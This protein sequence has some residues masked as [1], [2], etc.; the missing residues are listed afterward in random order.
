MQSFKDKVV[1]I[2]GASSG[3][4]EA[5]AMAFANEGAKL[6]LTARREEELQRVK[7][8]T[9]LPET[10][11]LVLP[12]DVTQFEKAK[13]AA[14]KVIAHFGRIDIMVHNAGVSQRSYINDTDL[15]V[16]QMLMN[17]NFYS[18]V[19]ITKAILPYMIQQKSG[20]FIVISSVAGKIGTIMRSGYNASK[21]ALQG[22]YDSLRAEGYK[23]NIKVT[24]ICPGYIRTNISLNALNENGSK[25]GKMDANQ[26][27]GIAP[28]ECAA[29]I[30]EAVKNDK[31][32]IYIGGMKEVAA[33]YLKRFFPSF[34]F[35]Q[36]RK[37]IPE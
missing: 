8:R 30:L 10:S 37:N 6:V 1:W 19:A 26:E 15:D 36:I 29:R 28:E 31:K 14:E 24:T 2:T 34:L 12:M 27:K 7:K 11:V 13:P 21:H 20:H 18:T 22:F 16:Y 3:I 33:I 23:D 9:G 17:V 32:E 5:I 25:F 35:D 4:G